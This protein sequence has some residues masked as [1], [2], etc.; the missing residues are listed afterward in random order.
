[1]ARTPSYDQKTTE[2]NFNYVIKQ[3]KA[4]VMT[5]FRDRRFN[6]E[7]PITWQAGIGLQVLRSDGN[8]GTEGAYLNDTQNDI[9]DGMA[10]FGRDCI[11]QDGGGAGTI[12][13][14]VLHSLSGTMAI[15]ETTLKD[16][17]LMM[18]DAQNKKGGL[19]ARSLSR[20]SSI[21][22][23]TGR[24]SPR[25]PRSCSKRTK[26]LWCLGAGLR[27]PENRCCRFSRKTTVCSFIR[28]STRAKNRLRTSSIPALRRTSRPSPRWIT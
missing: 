1:M 27:F 16:T 9:Y 3:F 18:I 17:I 24:S 13:V 2:V 25:R 23:Q 6:R 8:I 20:W 19:L 5:F 15:S 22:L 11:L 21:R 28:F 26:S 7:N 10:T 14:G 4:R 12:K